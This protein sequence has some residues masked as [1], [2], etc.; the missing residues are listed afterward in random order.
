MVCGEQ[1]TNGGF[2]SFT[3][4][5]PTGW[6]YQDGAGTGSASAST[7][8][9]PFPSPYGTSTRSVLMMDGTANDNGPSIRQF[10]PGVTNGFG[11]SFDFRLGGTSLAG[12][13]WVLLPVGEGGVV[14]FNLIIDAGG[15][16]R[17]TDGFAQNTM[18]NLTPSTW[19]HV[20]AFGSI[21]T[22]TYRG[23]ITPLG[24]A[25]VTWGNMAFI[26]PAQLDQIRGIII[27]DSSNTATANSPLYVDNLSFV[28]VPEPATASMLALGLV[29]VAR[30]WRG[31][32]IKSGG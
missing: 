29:M 22:A 8:T 28:A 4:G 3:A 23:S 27:S 31:R 30:V 32:R 11:L 16:F 15:S 14:A 10:F 6:I 2:E 13:P 1:L 12:D 17:V 20:E 21:P 24:G 7:L 9:S 26:N 25:T 19:Y 5:R 18:L